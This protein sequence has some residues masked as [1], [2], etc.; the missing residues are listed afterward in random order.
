MNAIENKEAVEPPLFR[1]ALA[2]EYDGSQYHGWQ[3]QSD[4][5][6]SVQQ[7]VEYALGQ[8]ADEPVSVVCA[9]RTDS[10]VH[11]GYQIIHFDTQAVRPDRAWVMGGNTKL[12]NDICFK[13]VVSV[14]SDFH[15]RFSAQ[16]RRYRYIIYPA[17][18]KPALLNS[19]V[20]WTRKQLDAERMQ[21]A[22]DYLVGTHDFSSY[23][24][25]ACQAK[26][27]VRDVRH[28]RVNR[29]GPFVVID[30]RANAFLHHMIRN[31]AGVLMK[32]GAGEAE[33]E[34]AKVVLDA[35][36]R[37]QGGVTAHPYGLYFVDVRYPDEH[38][39]PCADIGP[40]FL[41]EMD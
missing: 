10:G 3:R 1:Y 12:P 37:R 22:G 31:I 9:G 25:V 32:I 7:R 38:D 24:A 2:V 33:P 15:A 18:V 39:L 27:P 29:I 41:P 21:L 17:P 13:W 40:F 35:R 8:I 36:D 23:R 30:V 28:L 11:A 5:V 4:D 19:Q 16:E 34:W 14:S 26:S 6:D 20:T